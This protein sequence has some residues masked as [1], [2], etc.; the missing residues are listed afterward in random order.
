MIESF[1]DIQKRFEVWEL[2]TPQDQ[3]TSGRFKK[4]IFIH[5]VL[6]CCTP[7]LKKLL[8]KEGCSKSDRRKRCSQCLDWRSGWKHVKTY[9]RRGLW[10]KGICK[11]NMQVVSEGFP[12]KARRIW[13]RREAFNSLGRVMF[14]EKIW[15]L[16]SNE[17]RKHLDIP[18]TNSGPGCSK[19]EKAWLF[20]S[21]K[22]LHW[23][24]LAPSSHVLSPSCTGRH[25]LE[26][27]SPAVS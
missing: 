18:L 14:G 26:L 12:S 11:L 20:D 22:K 2:N 1:G 13:F 16:D 7:C 8:E 17:L 21:T 27:T 23:Y 15:Y 3:E 25:T 4:S 10:L 24:A 6:H 5:T 9:L 19:S